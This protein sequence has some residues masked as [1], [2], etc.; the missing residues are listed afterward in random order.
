MKTDQLDAFDCVLV[1]ALL[2]APPMLRPL[3]PSGLEVDTSPG[4]STS[5]SASSLRRSPTKAVRR[6]TRASAP[7]G[8]APSLTGIPAGVAVWI[9]GEASI[10]EMPETV[11]SAR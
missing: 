9:R 4:R 6:R 3:A 8:R 10:D 2:V 11:L 7:A 1:H 5:T